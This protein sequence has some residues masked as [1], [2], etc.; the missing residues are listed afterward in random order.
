PQPNIA[1]FCSTTLTLRRG[2]YNKLIGV[3]LFW[4]LGTFSCL[5]P[6]DTPNQCAISI[7]EMKILDKKAVPEALRETCKQRL[8]NALKQTKQPLGDLKINFEV[9]ITLLEKECYTKYG[10]I[11]KTF[12]NSQVAS[13]VRW[14]SNSSS[15]EITRR[16]GTT[17]LEIVF[18]GIG[19]RDSAFSL[20]FNYSKSSKAVD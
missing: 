5:A 11:G 3:Q 19:F 10:N 13:T 15:S 20:I 16:L 17:E 9:S 18:E 4:T 7:R 14:L 6:F 1:L 8:L 2:I 12:Y